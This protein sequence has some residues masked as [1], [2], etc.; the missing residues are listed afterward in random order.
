MILIVFSTSDI[1]LFGSILF[2][3]SNYSFVIV[4]LFDLVVLSTAFFRLI[5][6]FSDNLEQDLLLKLSWLL[7][8]ISL[9]SSMRL[10][11][12]ALL[13]KFSNLILDISWFSILT[14][15]L[16]WFLLILLIFSIFLFFL[17]SSY[18]NLILYSSIN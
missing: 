3:I 18:F 9:S 11:E 1:D 14:F 5:L 16:L 13:I 10:T 17:A 2:E 15:F 6:T 12:W 7:L 4:D 8:L